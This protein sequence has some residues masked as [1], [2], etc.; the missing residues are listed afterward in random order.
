MVSNQVKFN[1]I[2]ES[3]EILSSNIATYGAPYMQTP[4]PLPET[5][6]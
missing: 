1:K 4:R 6:V 2:I 5:R 3:S